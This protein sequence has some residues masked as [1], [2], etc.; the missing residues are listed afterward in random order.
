MAMPISNC[1]ELHHPGGALIGC[2]GFKQ[3]IPSKRHRFGMKLFILCDCKTRIN[4]DMIEYTG[5]KTDI[6]WSVRTVRVNR[7]NMPTFHKK[8]MVRGDN[9]RQSNGNMTAMKWQ[10]KWDVCILS[11]VHKGQLVDSGE[12]TVKRMK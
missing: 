10:D 9:E 7:K 4:L 6:S 11:T 2:L 5:K 3:Y 8:K 12:R 1:P